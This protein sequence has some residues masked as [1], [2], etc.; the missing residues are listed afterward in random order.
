MTEQYS[1]ISP[2]FTD[3]HA[4]AA[5]QHPVTKESFAQIVNMVFSF[6]YLHSKPSRS[7]EQREKWDVHARLKT[8][9]VSSFQL[10]YV[11]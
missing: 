11:Q 6:Q 7:A 4:V 5:C 1:R 9:A 3:E 8:L 10:F 2:V